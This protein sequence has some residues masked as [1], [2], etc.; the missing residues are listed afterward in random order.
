[1][2]PGASEVTIFGGPDRYFDGSVFRV[3]DTG[4]P[5]DVGRD[6]LEGPALVNFD[7]SLV[8]NTSLGEQRS[9]QFRAEMFNIFN[10]PNLG[11]PLRAVVGP[12]TANAPSGAAIGSA[13]RIQNTST[14][15][16]QVQFGLKLTF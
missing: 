12:A 15:E 14:R 9:L 13:G 1:M 2:K 8:K 5:G 3:A 6:T 4:F 11:L 7:F 16:R 10:H